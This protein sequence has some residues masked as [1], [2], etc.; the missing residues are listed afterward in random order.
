MELIIPNMD[1]QASYQRYIEELG[2][3]EGYPFPL[4]FDCSDFEKLLAKLADFHHGKNLPQGYVPSSTLW[5]V[6]NGEI[7][8]VT[9]LRHTLNAQIRRCGGHI[10]LGIRPSYRHQGLGKQLIGLSIAELVKMGI[11]EIHIHCYQHNLASS[12]AIIANGGKLESQLSLENKVVLRYKVNH[13]L[14]D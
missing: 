9:N 7:I 14:L 12:K 8:G 5:L 2:D 4:D 6:D 3:E 1:F 13:T 10:G 11:N